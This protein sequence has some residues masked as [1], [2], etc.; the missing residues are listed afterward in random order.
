MVRTE[1]CCSTHLYIYIYMSPSLFQQYFSA[2]CH[3]NS[4]EINTSR[5][6]SP[7]VKTHSCFD[8]LPELVLLEVLSYLSC[9]DALDAFACVNA[10]LNRLLGERGA[11]YHIHLSSSLS[12]RQWIAFYN[13]WPRY[14]IQSLT[15]RDVFTNLLSTLI[16]WSFP[17]LTQLRLIDLISPQHGS[18]YFF[19]DA[20]VST[21]TH[22]TFTPSKL[23]YSPSGLATILHLI[24]PRLNHLKRLDLVWYNKVQVEWAKLP[25]LKT[26]EHVT[27]CVEQLTDMYDLAAR[28]PCLRSLRVM[29]CSLRD[30]PTVMPPSELE[31][32]D[33]ETF[34]YRTAKSNISWSALE[35]FTSGK[36][37]P[38]LRRCT[39]DCA[40][41]V[42]DDLNLIRASFL[43]SDG[44]NVRVRYILRY[45]SSNEES[46]QSVDVSGR[47][48]EI[49]S[50]WVSSMKLSS[51]LS[52]FLYLS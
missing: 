38:S 21:L 35:A 40:L 1:C 32:L 3:T 8:D 30:E 25:V 47:H 31:L 13:M 34:V 52:C 19:V 48:S 10:L 12:R 16:P 39:F 22:L 18:M 45:K 26:L 6:K 43:L 23:I 42:I 44:R 2:I 28:M 37:M 33:I 20:H 49:H 50:E 41:S 14:L 51:R 27:T 11:F 4:I 15:V 24:L 46:L 7:M 9:E 29:F 36:V 17:S 5:S